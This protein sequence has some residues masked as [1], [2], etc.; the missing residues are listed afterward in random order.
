MLFEL[1]QARF[2]QRGANHAPGHPLFPLIL[3]NPASPD[4]AVSRDSC[5]PSVGN[6][7]MG[8]L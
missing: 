8:L 4:C 1:V 6:G 2:H 7:F 5:A 3:R